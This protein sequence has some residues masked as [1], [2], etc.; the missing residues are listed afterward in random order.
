MR[1]SASTTFRRKRARPSGFSMLGGD[2]GSVTAGSVTASSADSGARHRLGYD[3]Y[4]SAAA[5]LAASTPYSASDR[6]LITAET[7]TTR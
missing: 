7:R 3:D 5:T 2:V 6:H 1:S 4:G